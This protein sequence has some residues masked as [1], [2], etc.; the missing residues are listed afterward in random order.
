MSNQKNLS[1][2]KWSLV[3]KNNSVTNNSYRQP[4]NDSAIMVVGNKKYFT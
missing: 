2:E 1:H 4:K 3:T